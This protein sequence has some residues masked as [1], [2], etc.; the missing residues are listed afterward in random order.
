MTLRQF[1]SE[2]QRFERERGG[3]VEVEVRD[4]DAGRGY[5][6]PDIT[7]EFIDGILLLYTE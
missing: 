4:G 2:L 7:I 1:I 3:E 5:G 6:G